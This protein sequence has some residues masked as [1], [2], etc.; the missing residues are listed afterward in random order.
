MSAT[1]R[2]V[3]HGLEHPRRQSSPATPNRRVNPLAR[4]GNGFEHAARVNLNQRMETALNA[5][6]EAQRPENTAKTMDNKV[7][8]FFQYCDHVY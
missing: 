8:E 3:S 1:S 7:I 5:D 6:A 2:L 4:H